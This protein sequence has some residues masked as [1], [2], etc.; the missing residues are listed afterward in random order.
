M[1]NKSKTKVDAAL[2]MTIDR[3]HKLM[4][5]ELLVVEY[6]DISCPISEFKFICRVITSGAVQFFK[7]T[8]VKKL[9][10]YRHEEDTNGH[11]NNDTH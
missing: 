11:T 7:P 8:G 4:P 10:L 2:A 6:G 1:K 3:V 5:G 9:I